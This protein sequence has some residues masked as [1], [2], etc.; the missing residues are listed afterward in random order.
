MRGLP[1]FW[2]VFEGRAHFSASLPLLT[3]VRNVSLMN[4]YLYPACA[5]RG[6]VHS[7]DHAAG[8]S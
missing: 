7:V 2:K 1:Y 4:P 6:G 3:L 5:G 8:D